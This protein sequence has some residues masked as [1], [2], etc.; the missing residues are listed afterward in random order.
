MK[1]SKVNLPTYTKG[2]EIFNAVSHG[3]GVP[4]GILSCI[5]CLLKATDTNAYLGAIIFAVSVVVL[6]TCSTL[7]HSL[8]KSDAKKIMRL[9][10]HST[11]FILITGT[12]IALTV[13]CVYPYNKILAI[14]MSTVSFL[15]ST[16][17]TALTFIDQE[18]YKKVQMTLYMIVGWISAVLIYPIYKNCANGAQ[19]ISLIIAGGIIYT[20]GTA[21]YAVGKKKKYFHSI[22]HIFV[23]SGTLLH[24]FSIYAAI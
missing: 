10:D 8:K 18:K 23:L 17:G 14:V 12:S 20:V 6:Y 16:I 24:F 22:F 3:M 13:I 9:L 2:E 21:F 4:L 19:I 1:L 11:I 15:L 5:F 7:Y